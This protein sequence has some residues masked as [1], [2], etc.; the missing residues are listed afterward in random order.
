MRAR[1]KLLPILL[2]ALL[3]LPTTSCKTASPVRSDQEACTV[4]TARITALRHQPVTHVA[5]CDASK[6]PELPGYYIVS[7]HA[8][9]REELCGSTLMGWF[10][11]RQTDG[12]VFDFEVGEWQVGK[13][14]SETLS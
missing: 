9:C 4:A 1:A 8:Y 6:D 10:A 14:V 7:L 13:P 12:A 3:A 5:Y 2:L 11:V